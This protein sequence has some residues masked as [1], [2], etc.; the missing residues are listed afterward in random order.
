MLRITRR[1]PRR[2]TTL[3]GIKQAEAE[4]LQRQYQLDQDFQNRARYLNQLDMNRYGQLAAA[5]ATMGL[6]QGL[7]QGGEGAAAGAAGAAVV[8]GLGLGAGLMAGA[9]VPM[10]YGPPGY[11]PY[12]PPGYPPQGYPPAGYPP[13]GYPPQGYPPAP[14]GWVPPPGPPGGQPPPVGQSSA[15]SS[16]KRCGACG[17]Q[18]PEPARFCAECGQKLSP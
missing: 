8:G 16:Q 15:G 12:L 1:R 4:A 6:G 14:A 18:N 10:P 7:A 17:S 2:R 9:R 5:E 3:G 13:A 11:P